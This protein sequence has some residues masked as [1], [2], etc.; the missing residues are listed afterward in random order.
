MPLMRV[1]EAAE[2]LGVHPNTLRKYIDKGVI[3]GV[4]I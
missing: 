1:K 2:Y 3:R 4:R